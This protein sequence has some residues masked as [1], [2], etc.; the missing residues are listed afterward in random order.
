MAKKTQQDDKLMTAYYKA[1]DFFD[2]NKKHVYT[3]LVILAIAIAG[4]YILVQKK[5]SNN[6]IASM[7]LE[8]IRPVYLAN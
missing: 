4:I 5:K 1:V 7:E 8:K 3:A 6:E 2:K